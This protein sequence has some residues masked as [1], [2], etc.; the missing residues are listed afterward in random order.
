MLL[1]LIGVALALIGYFFSL[2]LLFLI[3]GL[4]CFILDIYGFVSGRLN[5]IFPLLLYFLGYI[6]VESWDGVLWGSVFGNAIDSLFFVLFGAGYS[7]Y[8]I[9][10]KKV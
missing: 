5:P 10:K 1:Q 2:H 6:Y 8:S 9:F 4:L 7:I 3:G